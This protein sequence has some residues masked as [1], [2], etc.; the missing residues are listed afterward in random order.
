MS[1]AVMP[2]APESASA[3]DERLA[4]SLTQGVTAGIER[5]RASAVVSHGLVVA[6]YK[7]KPI[8]QRAVGQDL[9]LRYLF[10]GEISRQKDADVVMAR[11]IETATGTTVWS[12]RLTAATSSGDSDKSEL[13]AQLSNRL[14]A[15]LYDAEQKRVARLPM[16]GASAMETVLHA[17]RLWDQDPTPKGLLAAHRL[18][19]EAL[20]QDS[21]SL[22]AV[23]GLFWT[24]ALQIELEAEPPE[25]TVRELN[26]L[27]NRAI[28]LTR[29]DP[30]VW[31]MRSYALLMQGQWQG[32][33]DANAEA[34]RIDP[35]RNDV[36]GDQGWLLLLTGQP[37][38][39]LPVLGRA[40][41][42][43]PRSPRVDNLLRWQCS[44]HLNLGQ[45]DEAIAACE[46]SLV[47]EE[48]SWTYLFLLGALAQKGDMAKA[49]VAKTR[50]LKLEPDIS[51]ARVKAPRDLANPLYQQQREATLYAGLR[52]MGIPER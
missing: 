11:L 20:R 45:Y 4:E 41:A 44:A 5:A 31:R 22:E 1:V 6:K 24:G 40:I 35:Y 10:E 30:R 14:R 26:D 9:N 3:D 23:I 21:N 28:V 49:E 13:A 48:Y 43:D 46:K 51:I 7:G 12:G 27:S 33:L 25:Q 50:L 37:A 19:E 2:F 17:G 52:K 32:A 8:D 42:L 36:V 29:D 34:L 47:L 15:A 39:A 18:Y 38:E 16:P